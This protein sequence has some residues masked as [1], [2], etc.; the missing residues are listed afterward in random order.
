MDIYEIRNKISSGITIYNIPL[1]VT[2]YARVSSEKDAQL[3]SLQ[4]Q[5]DYYCQYIKQN[6]NWTYIDG[7]IDEGISG[8]SVNK[9]NSF[10]QMIEDAKNKKF[11]LII[12]KEISRFSRSTLDSIR[13]TQK[14]L[15]N[16][17]A[18]FFQSDNINTILPDS[19][20]RLTLMSS[21]AQDEVR[22]LSE[23]IK[24]GLHQSIKNENILGNGNIWGYTKENGKLIINEEEANIIRLIFDLYINDGLGGHN[25]S[26]KLND[27]G[28][29]N[30]SGTEFNSSIVRRI[31][32][33]PKYKGTYVGLKTT[34]VDYKDKKIK[35]I[36]ESQW[37]IKENCK[38]IPSIIP[39]DIWDKANDI[40]Y[41]RRKIRES[42]DYSRYSNKYPLSGKITCLNCKKKYSHTTI[43]GKDAW[44][45]TTWALEGKDK[46]NAPILY[47][48]NLYDI[49]YDI[50]Q[51]NE[52]IL[53][54]DKSEIINVYKNINIKKEDTSNLDAKIVKIL[55]KQEKLL[56]LYLNNIINVD[57]YQ[58]QKIKFDEDIKKINNS[59]NDII[60][61]N[62]NFKENLNI[63][64]KLL[65]EFLINQPQKTIFNFVDKIF[66]NHNL[67]YDHSIEIQFI[68]NFIKNS[69]IN[70]L[71][72][73]KLN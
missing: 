40:L 57:V 5:I 19:E 11:D 52:P 59:K 23:R 7:Y 49:V 62:N 68:Y 50:L 9:R 46:C 17:V 71:K 47:T 4:N 10:L 65:N 21:I 25:I 32:K 73:Q 43:N 51:K 67:N 24:F 72:K 26:K 29:R 2:F 3:N 35:K 42:D 8:T 44:R 63:I 34:R 36:D 64:K 54:F 69:K 33:N 12:T 31:I 45:C 55:H 27:M 66:V 53:N 41:Q 37:Y 70:I 61:I 22:K 1:N 60:N 15:Q 14:L 56:D 18:V 6:I 39:T 58:S 38:N 13:Y 48:T 28:Y 20:L 16:G 30:K